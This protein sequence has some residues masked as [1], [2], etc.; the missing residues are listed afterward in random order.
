[1][2]S[3]TLTKEASAQLHKL[4][5]DGGLQK[6]YKAVCSALKKMRAN[7]RYPGLSTHPL[8]GMLCPHKNT[9]YEAYAEN[10]TPAAYRI[11]WCYLPA[12]AKDSILVVQI[13]PH[14]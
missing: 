14:L 13:I 7:L 4:K 12:P 10:K 5:A 2:P 9:L 6:R 11:L 3:V 1:M 8:N